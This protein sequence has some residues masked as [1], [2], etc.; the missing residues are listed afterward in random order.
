[1]IRRPTS[2]PHYPDHFFISGSGG[3]RAAYIF[4]FREIVKRISQC[5]DR[6]AEPS[7]KFIFP[8]HEFA[9]LGTLYSIKFLNLVLQFFPPSPVQIEVPPD[10]HFCGTPNCIRTSRASDEILAATECRRVLRVCDAREFYENIFHLLRKERSTR[11]LQRASRSAMESLIKYTNFCPTPVSINWS[12]NTR[13][14]WKVP[15]PNNESAQL[16]V[17]NYFDLS[18]WSSRISLHFTRRC[19]SS[20]ASFF[21][22]IIIIFQ[23]LYYILSISWNFLMEPP[24]EFPNEATKIF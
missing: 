22:H 1:M 8:R 16:L 9:S 17:W 4:K 7:W 6:S 5:C 10:S 20:S 14:I 18:I 11:E 2:R 23:I 24:I 12:A 21:Y 3:S 15:R 19:S 13:E